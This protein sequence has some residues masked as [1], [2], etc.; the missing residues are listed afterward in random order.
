M[1][2]G[3]KFEPKENRIIHGAGQSV[4]QFRK[5]WNIMECS[6]PAIYM[7]YLKINTVAEKLGRIKE[8]VKEFPGLALQI[9]LN[10]K[11]K[12]GGEKT[13]E[14][15][16]GEYDKEILSLIDFMK[17]SKRLFFLRIGYE[18]NN[19][20]HNYKS[21][22]FVLAWKHIVDLFRRNKVDNVAF[23]WDACTAFNKD[24]KDVMY[25]YPGD[26]YVDWF[27]NNLFGAQHFENDGDKITED[28]AKESEQHKKPLMICESSAIRSGVLSGKESWDAWFK[29][30]FKWIKSHP[31]V[32]AFCYINWDWAIDWKQPEWGNGRIEENEFVKNSY[33][34]E[35]SDKRYVHL[36]EI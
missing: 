34:K 11:I 2:F 32:K 21:K 19:P 29:P 3:Q 25:Y 13:R 33:L 35:L 26:E 18:F 5:Y 20:D 4:E 17:K 16:M 22:E 36:G 8:E 10:L 14:I 9:G 15:V 27:G 23:V 24:I 31:V 28:F 30:Y 1:Y 12:D 6:R 7:F